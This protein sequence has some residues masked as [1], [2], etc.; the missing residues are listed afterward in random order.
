MTELTVKKL[1]YATVKKGR[2][3]GRKK[4]VKKVYRIE[5]TLKNALPIN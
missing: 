1:L 4:E 3:G 2:R 5:K